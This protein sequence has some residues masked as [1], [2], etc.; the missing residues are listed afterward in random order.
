MT[1]QANVDR[2]AEIIERF[3]PPLPG[4]LGTVQAEKTSRALHAAGLL[5]PDPQIIR[6]VEDLEALDPYDVIAYKSPEG[7]DLVCTAY[8]A[9]IGDADYTLPVATVCSHSTTMS[10]LRALNKEEIK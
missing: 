5:A 3:L 2:A 1:D 4:K 7:Y 6:T 9:T 10:A 8:D